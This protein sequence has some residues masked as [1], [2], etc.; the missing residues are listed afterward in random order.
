MFYLNMVEY[1][2]FFLSKP[3][4][5]LDTFLTWTL[6]WYLSSEIFNRDCQ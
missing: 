1:P 5:T 3:T 4:V 2:M 6:D